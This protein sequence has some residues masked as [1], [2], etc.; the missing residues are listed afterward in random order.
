MT[1][2]FV[3]GTIEDPEMTFQRSHQTKN[4]A[5]ESR[6]SRTVGSNDPDELTGMDLER[7]IFKCH[8]SG[9]AEGGMIEVNDRNRLTSHG[10]EDSSQ[11]KLRD[12]KP[13]NF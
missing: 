7:D 5:A 3:A 12:P 4:R 1:A 11:S 9:K 13:G 6:L 8:H 10:G 2:E